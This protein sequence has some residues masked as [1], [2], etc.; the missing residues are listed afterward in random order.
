MSVNGLSV[1]FNEAVES[2]E[3][4]APVAPPA[5]RPAAPAA[6][7]VR[8]DPTRLRDPYAIVPDARVEEDPPPV[9]GGDSDKGAAEILAANQADADAALER[10]SPGDRASYDAIAKFLPWRA[11]SGGEKAKVAL[12]RLLIDGAFERSPGLLPALDA[13]RAADVPTG[14]NKNGLLREVIEEIQNPERIDQGAKGTCGASALMTLL[15]ATDP[16]GYARLVGGLASA[17]GRARLANGAEI[18]RE[19]DFRD[20]F[21]YRA[22]RTISGT[23]LA[24]ALMDYADGDA[25]DYRNDPD[26]HV[27]A[28]EPTD[29]L[30]QWQ[31][32]RLAS[33]LFGK[34]YEAR[35]GGSPQELKDLTAS[36]PVPAA[37][38]TAKGAHAILVTRVASGRVWFMDSAGGK[39]ESC[40]AAAFQKDLLFH[41]APS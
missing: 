8:P 38:T 11:F 30:D 13:I 33:G 27:G 7:F 20:E 32:A 2:I 4:E 22:G 1:R 3:D 23:L 19:P 17:E 29:G 37:V 25:L 40:D 16:A 10:L 26:K 5:A 12:Q 18:R 15:A 41:L 28:G 31:Y 9:L 14:F 21:E 34:T 36:G 39:L 35:L 24:P 6:R